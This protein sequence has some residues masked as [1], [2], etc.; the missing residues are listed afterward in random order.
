RTL[1]HPLRNPQDLSLLGPA[2]GRSALRANRRLLRTEIIRR[3]FRANS[4]AHSRPPPARSNVRPTAEDPRFQRSPFSQ[5]ARVPWGAGAL[6]GKKGFLKC[7]H[8]N[9]GD[10]DV[11]QNTMTTNDTD[12]SATAQRELAAD[13]LKQA[14]QDLRRFH[15][16]TGAVERE[17]YS[18][19]YSWV[20]SDD[21]SWPFS[22]LNVCHLLDKEP[23][24]VREELLGDLLLGFFGQ[25]ARRGSQAVRRLSDSFSRRSATDDNDSA[26]TPA[27][28]Q[29]TS[30]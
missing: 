2:A 9:S 22:F 23:I 6:G 12:I 11:T 15:G 24:D 16:G 28:L 3:T 13:V 25:L 17:L 14:V 5:C 4:A 8:S 19:A 27:S 29:Q 7:P 21:C 20:T 26:T 1:L 18:D 30:C 10:R